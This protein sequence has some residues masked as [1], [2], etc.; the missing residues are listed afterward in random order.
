MSA[1]P[2]TGE[3]M[4]LMSAASRLTALSKASGGS[5]V[6]GFVY[7]AVTTAL[8]G[9]CILVLRASYRRRTA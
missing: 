1:C 8:A 9:V 3:R 2:A 7:L 6:T 5:Y 4:P